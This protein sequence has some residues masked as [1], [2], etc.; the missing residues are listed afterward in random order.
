MKGLAIF[1]SL[2]EILSSPLLFE[3][4]SPDKTLRTSSSV[5]VVNLKIVP[6]SIVE[7]FGLKRTKKAWKELL[8]RLTP[9]ERKECF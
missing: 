6:I 7:L 4:L 3:V 2:L 9:D 5:T 1:R 8:T